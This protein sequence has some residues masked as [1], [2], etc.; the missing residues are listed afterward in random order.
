MNASEMAVALVE[1][2][3][4]RAGLLNQALRDRYGLSRSEAADVLRDLLDSGEL[5][6]DWSGLIQPGRDI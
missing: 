5:Y 3:P 4:R 6:W 1:L 2:K